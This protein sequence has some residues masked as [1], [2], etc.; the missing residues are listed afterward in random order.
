LALQSLQDPYRVLQ[1][2]KRVA[3]RSVI[4]FPNFGFLPIRLQLL[5]RGRMPTSS[6]LPYMWYD[7]PNIHLFTLKD[8]TTLSEE[9]GFTQARRVYRLGGMWQARSARAWGVNWR[10]SYAIYELV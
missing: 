10:A 1:E 4:G 2:M 7:T 9:L 6:A 3:T 5:F 8:F